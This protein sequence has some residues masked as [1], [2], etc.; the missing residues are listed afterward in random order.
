MGESVERSSAG[1]LWSRGTCLRTWK[2]A[3]LNRSNVAYGSAGSCNTGWRW[4]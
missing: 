4:F 1:V 3:V 2:V